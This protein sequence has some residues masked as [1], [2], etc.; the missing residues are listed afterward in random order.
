LRDKQMKNAIA[1]LLLSR[2]TPMLLS[3]DEIK[4]S[5]GG[6]NNAY[7]QD[8]PISWIDWSGAK[9]NADMLNFFKTMI[10]FRKEHPVLRRS[11]FYTGYNSSGYPELSFHGTLPWQLDGSQPFLAFA[12]M[13]AE[14]KADYGTQKDAFI[15]CAVNSYWGGLDFELPVVPEG[16]Q[17][18][19]VAYTS[20]SNAAGNICTEGHVWVDERSIMLLIAENI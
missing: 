9:K 1:L 3:G 6:N 17:W 14:P 7:C 8:S 5:Q 12:F 19:I 11:D 18:R 4:N 10:A 13:Y 16:M 20:D 2:G 15:Y